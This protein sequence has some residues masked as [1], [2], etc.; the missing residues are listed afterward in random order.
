MTNTQ[1][2]SEI[3]DLANLMQKY[4]N[5]VISYKSAVADYANALNN[6]NTDLNSDISFVAI[7]GQAFDGTGSAGDS[8]ATTLQDCMA[9]CSSIDGCTGAT[10]VSNQCMV[11]TGDSPI[12]SS[13]EDSYAIIPKNKQ[14][15]L[16]MESLNEQLLSVNKELINKFQS[17][18]S[19]IDSNNKNILVKKEQLIN[20]YEKLLEERRNIAKTISQ[21]DTL[22]S[23]ETD[24]ELN[25]TQNYYW[26]V[27]FIFLGLIVI[28]VLYKLGKSLLGSSSEPVI[29]QMGGMLKQII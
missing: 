14:L 23:N 20:N 10:F 27:L 15:L 1:N 16:N 22:V 7:K 25:V 2:N 13:T 18:K 8:S 21:Y 24:T 28:I 17:Q 26:Y 19:H 3:I 5:L 9:S 29:T 6:K 11:R 12:I 4:S